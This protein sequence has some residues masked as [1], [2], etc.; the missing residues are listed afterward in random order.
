MLFSLL[1]FV[2]TKLSCAAHIKLEKIPWDDGECEENDSLRV[3]AEAASIA[4]VRKPL[5]PVGLSWISAW[6]LALISYRVGGCSVTQLD[7]GRIR[8]RIQFPWVQVSSVFCCRWCLVSRACIQKKSCQEKSFVLLTT[9]T[10]FF[11]QGNVMRQVIFQE[12]LCD[13]Y[14]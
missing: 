2:R 1:C 11:E 7:N 3:M 13:Y 12:W 6:V 14:L 5:F 9:G 10:K 4:T 8:T